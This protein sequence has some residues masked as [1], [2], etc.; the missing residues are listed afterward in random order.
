MELNTEHIVILKHTAMTNGGL[1]CGDS[2]EMQELVTAGLMEA[3][4]QPPW[5]Q[6]TYFHLTQAGKDWLNKNNA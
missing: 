6:Y 2:K 4:G 1:Y 5:C 3:V